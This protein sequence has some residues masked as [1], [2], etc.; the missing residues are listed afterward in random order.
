MNINVNNLQLFYLTMAIF[1]L[2]L[3][4]FLLPTL[5]HGPR[6]SRSRR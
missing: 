6:P 4:I 3:A 2:A 5:V 1:A